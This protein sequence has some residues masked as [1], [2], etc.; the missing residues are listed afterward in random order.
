MNEVGLEKGPK[1]GGRGKLRG[2]FSDE[3]NDIEHHLGPL[4]RS[5]DTHMTSVSCHR[6]ECMH[7]LRNVEDPNT[8]VI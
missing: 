5:H 7:D 2:G 4:V 8:T 3:D 1:N 6:G